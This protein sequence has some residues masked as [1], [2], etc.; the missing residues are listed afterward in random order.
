[1]LAYDESDSSTYIVSS[2]YKI[3]AN[4]QFKIIYTCLPDLEKNKKMPTLSY[5]HRSR[6]GREKT[7]TNGGN[8]VHQYGSDV[9]VPDWR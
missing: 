1:M 2:D 9:S 8:I 4:T 7:T 3:K 6:P 5:V